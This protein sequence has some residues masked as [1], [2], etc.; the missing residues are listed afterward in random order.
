[1][2]HTLLLEIGLEEM[3]A[4]FIPQSERQLGEKV[5]A[6]LNDKKLTYGEVKTFSTPRRLAVQVFDLA[7][8][9][10][11]VSD[12]VRGPSKKIAVDEDGNWTKAAEGFTRG[13]GKTVDDIVFEKEGDE[14]YVYVDTFQEGQPTF[15]ALKDLEKVILSMT[16]PINMRWGNYNL[17][18]IRPIHWIISL[19]DEKVIP[20]KILDVESGQKSRGHR[21][22]GEAVR[23]EKPENYEEALEK[24]SVIADRKKRRK[25]IEEQL[26]DLEKEHRFTISKDEDLLDEVT[27]LV[28]LPTA[29]VGEYDKEFLELPEEV[30]IVAM[31]DHQRYFGVYDEDEKL[32][33]YFI[34]VKNGNDKNIDL[35]RQGNERVLRA[36]LADAVFF[37]EEDQKESIED[38]NERL[39]KVAFYEG[40]GTMKDKVERLQDIVT[41]LGEE[42]EFSDNKLEK[43]VRAAEIA[44]FDQETLMVDEFSELQGVMGEIYANKF[45]EDSEV[46]QAIREQ[47]LPRSSEG[48]LP[49]T[50]I[51]A[52]LSIADKIDNILM[53]FAGGMIPSGSNDPHALRRQAYALLRITEAKDW[54]FNVK[55]LLSSIADTIRYPN[56]EV[57]ESVSDRLEDVFRFMKSRVRQ[58]LEYRNFEH[59]VIEAILKS[60]QEN[61][62]KLVENAETLEEHHSDTTFKE[63]IESL[64]RVLNMRENAQKE[65]K[66]DVKIA[67]EALES[68]S[69]KEL[70]SHLE[71]FEN[72]ADE[73]R[74]S[75]TYY[76]RL[77]EFA[78]L[79]QDF[80]DN[81]MVMSEEDELRKNR[82]SLI[83]RL[84]RLIH[85]FAAVDHL[86]IK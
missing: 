80:F 56:S 13:Q 66:E 51:G 64:T 17:E 84:S 6:Y 3:P 83:L 62:V 24:E 61:F 59:D 48:E 4:R 16:F 35:V 23:L 39:E 42:L 29:L 71:A 44:K 30:L 60:D 12:H 2:T 81:T 74:D 49:E 68:E 65:V 40:I 11:D 76:E 79:I 72:E 55:E 36:R 46:A 77:E 53:F 25:L 34:T 86:V 43:V 26:S 57:E 52:V 21:F 7:E 37:Y 75:E 31:K 63:V 9:Q 33:N 27:D 45:G 38:F 82:L 10:E 78:P 14:E 15:D 1:M 32:L 67:T 20:L 18:Y 50:D 47:Y 22:L 5:E 19:L 8:K 41:I 54:S 69:E 73:I 85:S 28:E 70:F 58:L